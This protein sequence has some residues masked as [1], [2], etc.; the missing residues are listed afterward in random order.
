MRKIYLILALAGVA[1]LLG[2]CASQPLALAPVG[3]GP[4]A[5]TA[6]SP[7][8]GD[9]QVFTETEEYYEDEISYFPHTDYQ[10]Y[11][12]DGK[13]L[14]HVW[15]HQDHEDEFPATVTLPPGKYVVKALAE[16]YGMVSVP[17]V[18]KPNETTTVIL[19]PGWKPGNVARSALV[20][21]PNGYN[22][23][24]RADLAVDK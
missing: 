3:P 23:G 9:L 2:A 4:G 8:K 10:I 16:F 14:K 18:I 7:A 15:N 19:Q 13:R 17:V 12:A 24:W 5:R 11:T 20:Q 6:S 1:F 21:M 22:V